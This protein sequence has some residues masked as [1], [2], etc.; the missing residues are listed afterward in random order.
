MDYNIS[1]LDGK[2]GCEVSGTFMDIYGINVIG[3][4]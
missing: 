4:V 3:W 1:H 2:G